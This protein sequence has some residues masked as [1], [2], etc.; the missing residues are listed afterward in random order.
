MGPFPATQRK[1]RFLLV[2]VD[3]FTRWIE[4]FPLHSTTSTQI[5]DILTNEVFTR[6]GLPK[7]ILSDNG[8][9]FVSNMF[10]S[11]CETLGIDQKL[12]ANY[13]PQ[14]N[15]TERVNRTLKPMIA[16]YAKQQ[17]HSWDKEVQKLAF[18]I[19]TS[20]NET[21]GETP[22][23]LMFGRDPRGP[24]D[25]IT[26]D[27]IG[28]PPAMTFEDAQIHEY[29]TNLINNLRCAYNTVREHSEIEKLNQKTKYDR[30]TTKREFTVGDLVWVEI[31]AGR[32]DDSSL[33]GKLQARYQGP[34]RIVHQLAPFTFNVRRISDNVDLGATNIDRL[35][36][37]FKPEFK[38]EPV[39]TTTCDLETDRPT[40]RP[41]QPDVSDQ[42]QR[43]QT[44]TDVA[45]QPR[46]SS[47]HRRAP[48]RYPN[49]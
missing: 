46:V 49:Q 11:F 39:A 10:K 40:T 13:H 42:P 21:T 33:R 35:K 2:I 47:R 17:P 12:T 8:P 22:A 41:A 27:P 28:G 14:S 43:E 48:S 5:A 15:M 26:G 29:K 34:C 6:Y 36:H 23:F 4:L 1:K 9:Q 19:R 37:Y 20:I 3:Y 16:I 24:L 45:V 38:N 7:F 30:H 25:L 44:P 18:A 32:I 31:P